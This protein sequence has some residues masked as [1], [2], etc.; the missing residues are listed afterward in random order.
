MMLGQL[1][2]ASRLG[3]CRSGSGNWPL[4]RSGLQQQEIYAL[5][6]LETCSQTESETGHFSLLK[7]HRTATC[8]WENITLG[9]KCCIDIA[10]QP[11]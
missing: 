8:P 4:R 5:W 2:G 3:L 7:F 6:L 10:A 9:E 1:V 11:T